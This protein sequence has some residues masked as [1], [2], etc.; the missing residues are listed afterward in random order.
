MHELHATLLA[1]LFAAGKPLTLEDFAK[2]VEAEGN[3]IIKKYY[4]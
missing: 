2:Q 4:P 1:L 3:E